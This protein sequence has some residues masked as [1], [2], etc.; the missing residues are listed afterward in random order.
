AQADIYS[1]GIVL[2]AISTGKSHQDFPEPLP[3]LTSRPDNA[4]WLDLDAIILKACQADVRRRYHTAEEMHRELLLLQRGESVRQKRTARRRWALAKKVGLAMLVALALL[5]A[6]A[7][8]LKR[9]KH[10]YKPRAEAASLYKTGQ[11]HYNQL[12]GE[13]HGKAFDYLTQA[14]QTDPK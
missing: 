7:P 8:F 1:L 10:A 11:W 4:R 12:T 9:A 13:A 3:D 2:Y 6:S 5:I 14:I